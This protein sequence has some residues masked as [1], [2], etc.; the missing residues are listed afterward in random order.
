MTAI[1]DGGTSAPKAGYAAVVDY[2]AGLLTQL[3]AARGLRWLIPAI[4][5]GLA[6]P[7]E[8]AAF[9]ASDPPA[10]PTFTVDETVAILTLQFGDD[11]DSGVGKLRDL[12]LHTIWYEVCEC[13]TGTLDTYAPPSMPTDTPVFQPPVPADVEPCYTDAIAQ[14]IRNVGGPSFAGHVTHNALYGLPITLGKVTIT[15]GASTGNFNVVVELRQQTLDGA[16]TGHT[17]S[18]TRGVGTTENIIPIDPLFPLWAVY[19]TGQAG[20]GERIVDVAS[21]F[22]CDGQVPGGTLTPCCPPD[23]STQAYLDLILKMVTL[24]QRQST[25]FGYVYGTNHTGLTGDGSFSVSGLI[26]VSVDVTALAPSYGVAAGTPETLYDLGFVTLGT[27]DG[28]SVSRR[29]DH[30]GSLVIPPNAGLFTEV[31]YTVSPGVTIDIREL[32]REP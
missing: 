29:I 23:E 5:L 16:T 32:V 22:Y 28:W 8:L 26:G 20:S 10:M 7:V 2:S 12:I 6:G 31:G 25:A 3:L 4:P 9:C 30:D 15:I 21:T 1:C 17:Y 13:T 14:Y 19:L 11:F 18:M 24:I 27:A